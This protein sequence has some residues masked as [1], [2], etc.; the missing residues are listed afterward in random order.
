MPQTDTDLRSQPVASPGSSGW[1]RL[2]DSLETLFLRTVVVCGLFTVVRAWVRM[3]SPFEMDYAEGVIFNS[4]W[5]S[6]HGGALYQPIRGLPYQIDPYPPFI[7]NL[8]GSV[9]KHTGLTFF[10]PRLLALTAAMAACFLAAI[11]IHHW[12]QRWKLAVIFGLLPLT[13]AAVQPWLGIIRYDLI[14][15][16]LTMAGLV[17]FVVFPRHR[18]WSLPFFVFGVAG[19]Y[20]LVAAP[21][22]CCLYLWM[23]REKLKSILFGACLAGALV[24]GFFY[25][26]HATAG[27]MGY[28]LFKTQQSPYS[29]SQ[30]ASF[31]Q[32]LLRGYSLLFLLSAVVV[33]KSIR[34]RQV[35]LIALYWLLVAGTALS[36]GKIGAAQNHLLQL[37]FVSCISAAVAYDWMRRRSS[38]DWGLALALGALIVMT[39]ANTPFRPRKP[40]ED[41]SEC[42]KA[43]SAIRGDLGDR[44]L[45][46]NVGALVLAAKPVYVSDPFVYGWLVKGAG[47]HDDD[48]RQMISSG[49]FTSIVLDREVEG[50]ETDEDRWPDDVRQAI[51]Q[52]YRLREQFT[53]NDAKFV[54]QPKNALIAG[55]RGGAE[56]TESAP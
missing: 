45:S 43:Y 49:K 47:M 2:I 20:T 27:Y 1:A 30:L 53:C 31:V 52:N 46:D 12:T 24:A 34:E 41:L 36:L 42:A 38:G 6:A 48:L 55:T 40:V 3:H 50:K 9:V 51:R 33:W 11:L 54:Y 32:A 56:S 22:A 37:V 8:V 26:Q 18:F 7:Y 44:I 29:V 10:Y 4:A 35:S 15:I 25:G 39:I 13:V 17:T 14:G 28:H 23:R 21:A 19:L 5:R 16:A